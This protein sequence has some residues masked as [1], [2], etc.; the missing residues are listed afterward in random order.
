MKLFYNVFIESLKIT[1]FVLVMMISVD[2]INVRTKGKLELLLKGGKKWKQYILASILGAAP[3]CLGSFAGVS[4]YIHGMISFG[5]LTG[6]MF[7]T[8][9]DEQFIMLAMF[10]KTAIMMFIIL[11]ILGIAVGYLTDYLVKIFNIKTCTDCEI[12][13]FHSEEK[14]YRHYLKEHIWAHIIKGHLVKTFLWTFGTLLLVE[15]SMIFIDLKSI[16]SEYMIWILV[17]S[18]L[19]GIIP[20]S[21]PH[22][23]FVMLFA[24]GVIPFS[25]LF[26]SS[27]VQDGHG[28]LPMLSYSI[29]D[30]LKIKIFNLVFGLA[31][32][33]FIYSLGF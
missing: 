19:I 7:A 32:G 22:L 13:Q 25:V 33:L 30:S 9:G 4:L 28:M 17:L 18:A 20:E 8:A 3:G 11:V 14:G 2:L 5:A 26:T 23:L 15:Y 1:I 6:L 21:G 16:G 10:P 29:K 27:I 24:K 31:I 12:K